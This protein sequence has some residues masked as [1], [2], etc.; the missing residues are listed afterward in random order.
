MC[1]GADDR[2]YVFF[3]QD[4]F[5][6]ECNNLSFVPLASVQDGI[7][8]HSLA[9]IDCYWA[10]QGMAGS[11]DVPEKPHYTDDELYSW[12]KAYN[13]IGAGVTLNIGI[14]SDGSLIEETVEQVCRI[15]ERL[16]S[17]K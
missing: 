16:I 4:F 6:G 10:V 7:Q 13:D 3:E 8:R 11:P 9:W 2:G 15:R 12:I 1:H 5:A 14:Y 17:E